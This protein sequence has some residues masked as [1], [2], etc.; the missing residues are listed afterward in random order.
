MNATAVEPSLG[1][2]LR[3]LRR[4]SGLSQKDLA[5]RAGLSLNCISLIER[6]EISPN[7]ATLQRLATALNVRIGRFFETGEQ[8][9]LV[10]MPAPQRPPI[11]D[12]TATG[13]GVCAG[14]SEQELQPFLLTLKPHAAASGGYVSQS[15]HGFVYCLKG[16]LQCEV[17]RNTYRLNPGEILLLEAALLQRCENAGEGDAQFLLVVSPFA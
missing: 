5:V 8:T 9:A 6:D 12:P 13:A 14:L 16:T 15:G 7:V 17:G 4:E 11:A 10:R 3:D 1:S 2:R